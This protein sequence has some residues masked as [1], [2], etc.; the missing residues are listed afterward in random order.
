MPLSDWYELID[1]QIFSA[2][3]VIN[4]YHLEKQNPAFQASE[5]FD[6]FQDSVVPSLLTVQ[7]QSIVHSEVT[8][9]NLA[10]PLDFFTGVLSPD[11]GLITGV[12]LTSFTAATI[13]FNRLRTDMKNGMKRFAAGSEATALTNF[14]T[15]GFV[16]DLT[17]LGSAVV[18]PWERLPFPGVEVC[19]FGIIKRVC[20]TQ[21]PPT[22]CPKYRLP[23][24]DEEL[25]F[26]IPLTF[27]VRDTIRSQVSRKRLV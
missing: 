17:T 10:D 26:Y 22:P 14:W 13:Q 11:E 9:R 12:A 6:A 21:P 8:V 3:T 18:L 24:T 23:E 2:Q 4:V 5:I 27:V 7:H 1:V 25:V 19:K 15:A 20:T 16:V